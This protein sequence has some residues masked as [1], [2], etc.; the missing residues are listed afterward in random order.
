MRQSP[1][2]ATEGE[3]CH[4]GMGD[5]ARRGGQPEGLGRTIEIA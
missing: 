5:D 1:D 3:S 2:P 4:A